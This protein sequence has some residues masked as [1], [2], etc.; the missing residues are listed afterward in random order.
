MFPKITGMKEG[1]IEDPKA[2]TT[3]ISDDDAGI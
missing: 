2:S 1:E 3:G